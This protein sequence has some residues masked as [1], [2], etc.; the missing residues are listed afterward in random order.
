VNISQLKLRSEEFD[1]DDD[2]DDND[3]NNISG[4]RCLFSLFCVAANLKFCMVILLHYRN[5]Q[6]I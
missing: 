3:N 2:D 1:D 5:L 4:D 6:L